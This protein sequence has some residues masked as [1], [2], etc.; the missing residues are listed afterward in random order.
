MSV[1]LHGTLWIESTYNRCVE[2]A[3]ALVGTKELPP[4]ASAVVGPAFNDNPDSAYVLLGLGLDPRAEPHK[5]S[6]F[7]GAVAIRA[8][9][10]HAQAYVI[11]DPPFGATEF[12]D[13]LKETVVEI[14]GSEIPFSGID[15]YFTKGKPRFADA[16]LR[17]LGFS[18]F[19]DSAALKLIRQER[20]GA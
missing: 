11:V 4:D 8:S 18:C 2:E 7:F 17:D 1:E 12:S 19:G 15:H 5:R 10:S 13:L 6:T 9:K 3:S 14:R 16:V 20:R